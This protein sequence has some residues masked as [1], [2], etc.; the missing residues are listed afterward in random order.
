MPYINSAVNYGVS[1]CNVAGRDTQTLLWK[2]GNIDPLI[3]LFQSMC[4]ARFTQQKLPKLLASVPVDYHE[5]AGPQTSPIL[6]MVLPIRR[7]LISRLR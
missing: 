1:K 2:T 6:S 4:P 3:H 7:Q 5:N